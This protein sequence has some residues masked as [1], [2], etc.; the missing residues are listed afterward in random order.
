[1]S[2]PS[3]NQ[4]VDVQKG[5]SRVLT[6]STTAFTLLFAV[7]LMLGVLAVPIQTELS[8]T[9]IQFTWLTAIAI[10]SGSLFRLPLGIL[11]DRF[12]GRKVLSILT[13]VTAIPC[14]L[15]STA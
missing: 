8:L 2:L 7:W 1:M 4:T 11:A 12:G 5:A 15:L 9:K 3:T 13:L 10:L 6:L 14:Y